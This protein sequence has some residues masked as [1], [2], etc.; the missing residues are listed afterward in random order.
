MEASIEM[1]Q[2]GIRMFRRPPKSIHYL[3]PWDQLTNRG[4]GIRVPVARSPTSR[5]NLR[6][7]L[8]LSCRS[9]R[10]LSG[11]LF[12]FAEHMR[13][14]AILNVGFSTVSLVNQVIVEQCLR[15]L[16]NARA[17]DNV[18]TPLIGGRHSGNSQNK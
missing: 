10:L 1:L 9:F 2:R 14:L 13:S 7:A 17:G 3:S 8:V 15:R 4:E 6:G 18:L 12:Q 5:Q 11:A 16:S